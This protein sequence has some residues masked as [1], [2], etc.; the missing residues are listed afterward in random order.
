M[1]PFTAAPTLV[2]LA[3]GAAYDTGTTADLHWMAATLVDLVD[4]VSQGELVTPQF[5]VGSLE[6]APNLLAAMASGNASGKPVI[7]VQNG[8]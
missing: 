8:N 4:L 7:E 6:E 1:P 5:V 2:E 3:L